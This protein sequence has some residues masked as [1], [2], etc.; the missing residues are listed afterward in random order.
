MTNEINTFFTK[1]RKRDFLKH[2]IVYRR[3]KVLGEGKTRGF[4]PMSGTDLSI[5][6]LSVS[7]ADNNND[8]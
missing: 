2:E 8:H 5:I 7:L 4:L 1:I 6:R 3:L